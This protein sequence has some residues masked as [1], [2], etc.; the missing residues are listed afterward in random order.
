VERTLTRCRAIL[1]LTVGGL[2]SAAAAAA[3]AG[4]QDAD[5]DP[6]R[7]YAD[8]AQLDRALEAAAIWE[9]RLTGGRSDF[10]AAWKLARAC[11]WLGGHVPASERKKQYER[12]VAAGRHAIDIDTTRPEGHFWMAANMGTLAES[13]GLRAGLRYRGAVKRELETVLQIDP[14]FGEGLAD[15]ALGRWYLRVP[16]LFGGSKEKSVEHLQRALTYDERSAATHLY[17]AETY[18]AMD[19]REE[20]A[21][22][23]QRVLEAPLH[24]DWVPE[25]GEFKQRA[26]VLLASMRRR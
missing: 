16:G 20:A 5:R 21:A 8:R 15:R 12:G 22:E 10:E 18:L 25:V 13:F 9:G 4:G 1:L 11:Y 7:L 17:L 6:D 26:T 24:P 14:R 3:R 2:L 19:R 23:L